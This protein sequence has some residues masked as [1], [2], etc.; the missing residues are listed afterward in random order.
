MVN[1]LKRFVVSAC[2]F[3]LNF[4][5]YFASGLHKYSVDISDEC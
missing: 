2:Q 5:L 1:L 3:Q 4:D